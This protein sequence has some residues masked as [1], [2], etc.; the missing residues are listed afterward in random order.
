MTRI[1]PKLFYL[2]LLAAL[3]LTTGC[4][5]N[6]PLDAQQEG[7]FIVSRN[8][9]YESSSDFDLRWTAVYPKPEEAFNPGI[10][11]SNK[12]LTHNRCTLCHEC[13]FKNAFDFDNYGTPEWSPQYTG[14]QWG[15]IVNRMN[16]KEGSLMNETIAERIFNYLRDVTLGKYDE[17]ADLKGAV[18]VEVDPESAG[19]VPVESNSSP[20]D[21]PA[22]PGSPSPEENTE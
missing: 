4:P 1:K 21:V 22:E 19:M 10:N 2:I 6:K 18:V 17:E 14:Q 15:P 16:K 9:L 7:T 5:P 20:D 3:L 13:G 11:V 12:E 8:K